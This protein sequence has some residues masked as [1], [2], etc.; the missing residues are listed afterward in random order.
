MSIVLLIISKI[1]YLRT[2]VILQGE[3]DLDK[4]S[5]DDSDI[6]YQVYL[7]FIIQK[8]QYLPDILIIWLVWLY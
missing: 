5:I 4:N 6:I 1:R 8:S 3:Y 7:L 2:K